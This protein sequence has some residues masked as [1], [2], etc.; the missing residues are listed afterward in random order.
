MLTSPT[1]ESWE[2]FC[3]NRVS[4]KSSTWGIGQDAGEENGRHQQHRR[5]RPQD[6]E[7]GGIHERLAFGVGPPGVRTSALL[8][9]RNFSVPSTTTCSSGVRPL[10]I[11]ASS[12]WVTPTVT[13]RTSTVWS[14]LTT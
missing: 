2:I 9:S 14:P 7:T 4:A 13:G 5:H 6:E 8:P 1:P 11:D 10:S 12:R 3:A